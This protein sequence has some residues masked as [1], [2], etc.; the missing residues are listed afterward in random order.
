[1]DPFATPSQL[2]TAVAKPNL[3]QAAALLALQRAAGSIRSYC[4]WNI[5]REVLVDQKVKITRR[6]SPV[7]FLPTLHLI[8]VQH[9]IENEVELDATLFHF[10]IDDF[11]M[12]TRG[13]GFWWP[14]PTSLVISYTH[15]Y[16]DGDAAYDVFRDVNL[17]LAARRLDNPGGHAS[18]TTGS[19]SWSAGTAATG[20][21][22]GEEM[23]QLDP[24]V[25]EIP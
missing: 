25:L 22:T 24:Y 23:K 15:G 5:S 14:E 7:F 21:L 4:H 8:S 11:G 9:L 20:G 2:T 16:Q 19:E 13:A 10:T 12:V 1:M 18:E 17:S 6:Y 3:T